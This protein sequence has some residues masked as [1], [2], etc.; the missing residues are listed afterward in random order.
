VRSFFTKMPTGYRAK[1]VNDFFERYQEIIQADAGWKALWNAGQKEELDRFLAAHPEAMFARVA[2]K[3]IDE[4]GK[5]K[6]ERTAIHLSQALTPDQKKEKLDLLDEKVVKLAREANAFMS[7]DV[8]QALKMPSR[9]TTEAGVRKAMDLK[10]YY[11][12][13]A[14]STFDAFEEVRKAPRF[15][16][17]DEE[18]RNHHLAALLRRMRDEYQPVRKAGRELDEVMKPFRFKSL[19]DQPTR[20]QRAEWS[21]IFGPRPPVLY[22]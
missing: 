9:F 21:N 22:Q 12:M 19:F 4:M 17:L 1:S 7:Q 8:A 18:A 6:K 11:K 16:A 14:E 15:F 10:D 3:F 20:R 5:I 2:H 13:V